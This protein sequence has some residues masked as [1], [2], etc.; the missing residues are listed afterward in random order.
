MKI[1]ELNFDKCLYNPIKKDYKEL[2]KYSEF[3]NPFI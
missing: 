3:N 1:T 2:K